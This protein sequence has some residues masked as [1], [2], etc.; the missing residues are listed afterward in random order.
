MSMM[1]SGWD[2]FADLASMQRTVDRLMN[3]T[4]GNGERERRPANLYLPV[5]VRESS[6][7]YEV[8]APVPGFAPGDVDVTF[9]DGVLTI[10]AEHQAEQQTVEEGQTLAREFAWGSAVRRLTLSG[11]VDP[12]HIEAEIE[13]GLLKVHLPKAQRSQPRRIP[14]AGKTEG[15]ESNPQLSHAS[16]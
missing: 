4:L 16:S 9:A 3:S 14:I 5:N 7:G 6:S 11:D 10:K 13:N 8:E 12:E 15:G 2:P 1:V